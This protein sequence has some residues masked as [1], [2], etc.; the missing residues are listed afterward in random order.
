[1]SEGIL[2]L[3]MPGMRQHAMVTFAEA[4]RDVVPGWEDTTTRNRALKELF[5]AGSLYRC[6]DKDCIGRTLLERYVV[7]L[8]AHYACFA[9]EAWQNRR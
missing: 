6:G 4:R 8:Q 1:M 5:V 2:L 7:D 3:S 9:Y